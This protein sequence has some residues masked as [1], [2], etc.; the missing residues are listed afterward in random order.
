MRLNLIEGGVGEGGMHGSV[1]RDLGGVGDDGTHGSVQRD[2]WP[3][4]PGVLVVGA[5]LIAASV[6]VVT[7]VGLDGVRW[8]AD[9]L[10]GVGAV[11]AEVF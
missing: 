10:V 11:V 9:V 5:L 1:Q 6:C 2:L 3:F 4:V 8:F 7:L